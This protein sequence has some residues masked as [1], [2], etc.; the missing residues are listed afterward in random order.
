MRRGRS[1]TDSGATT[2]IM[3]GSSNTDTWLVTEMSGTPPR[4]PAQYAVSLWL[5]SH[6]VSYSAYIHT[7]TML[8]VTPIGSSRAKSISARSTTLVGPSSRV[9][10]R[11]V[12]VGMGGW[13][14]VGTHE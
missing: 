3:L 8:L 5:S 2:E 13:G 9:W 7:F 12:G 11:G 14:C 10:R 6:S 1:V 4:S